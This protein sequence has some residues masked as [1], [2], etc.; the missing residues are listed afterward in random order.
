MIKEINSKNMTE[1]SHKL[2]GIFSKI[3]HSNEDQYIEY[4]EARKMSAPIFSIFGTKAIKFN[5]R[6]FY[7]DTCT[8]HISRHRNRKPTD[9]LC[10]LEQGLRIF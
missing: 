9:M 1:A 8:L 10:E 5:K 7:K 4:M 3:N 2:T 6:L